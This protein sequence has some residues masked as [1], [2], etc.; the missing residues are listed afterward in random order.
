MAGASIFRRFRLLFKPLHNAESYYKNY[1]NVM[2]IDLGRMTI[3]SNLK[4]AIG[5]HRPDKLD[6][7]CGIGYITAFLGSRGVDPNPAAIAKAKAL[8]PA[9]H[10]DCLNFD[11]LLAEGRLYDAITCV[12]S[13]EHF[14][15]EFREHFFAEVNRL[16]KPE[17]RLFIVYDSM[18]HPLQ[19]LSGLIHPGML[20]TDPTHIHCWPQYRFRR[21]LKE[22]FEIEQEKGGNV[23]SLFLPLTNRFS[24][25]RMYVCRPIP[26]QA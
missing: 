25:A 26:R 16:L 23:L 19:L 10:Y 7:G 15:D 21:L 22:H 6:L 20:L 13:I 17:G 4:A 24:T 12:N 11:D 2:G 18:F 5:D 8:Y 1:D 14:E 3:Y 9:A